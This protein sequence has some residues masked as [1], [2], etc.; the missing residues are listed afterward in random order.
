MRLCHIFSISFPT[1]RSR[2]YIWYAMQ[3]SNLFSP[4]NINIHLR[5]SLFEYPYFC[6]YAALNLCIEL[7][8]LEPRRIMFVQYSV[9]PVCP[10]VLVVS[11]LSTQVSLFLS[12]SLVAALVIR[13]ALKALRGS[14]SK[15]IRPLRCHSLPLYICKVFIPVL[16]FYI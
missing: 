15:I 3:Y 6:R 9:K 14:F 16:L 4:P 8:L 2:K 5:V 13:C 7:Q 12:A 1:F 10:V 11:R